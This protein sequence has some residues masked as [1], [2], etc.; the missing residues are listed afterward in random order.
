MGI[1]SYDAQVE[2][3]LWIKGKCLWIS[4]GRSTPW[5]AVPPTYPEPDTKTPY[6][7]PGTHVI[8]EPICYLR[9]SLITL[10]RPVSSGGDVIVNGERYAFVAEPDAY[11]EVARFL[12][13]RAIFDPQEY[14]GLSFGAFRQSAIYSG[15]VPAAGHE[16]DQWLA[17]VNVTDPGLLEYFANH[18]VVMGPSADVEIVLECG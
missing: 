7:T 16:N 17:P 14:E 8:D 12:Y 11:T 3:T 4:I 10:A 13:L 1:T 9:P 2:R 5:P 15:L 6:E 18:T